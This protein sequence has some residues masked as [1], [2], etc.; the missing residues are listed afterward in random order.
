MKHLKPTT[1]GQRGAVLTDYS[2]LSGKRKVKRLV[3]SFHRSFGRSR[4]S[5]TVRHKGGGNKRLYRIIDF[6]QHK[7]NIPATVEALEYDPNRTGFIALLHYAD[8][9]KRYI[10]AANDMKVGDKVLASEKRIEFSPGNRMPLSH[11][12][13]GSFVHNIEIAPGRGGMLVRSAGASAKVLAHEGKYTNI[14]MPSSEV[15]K[16]LSVG[17]A[18]AGVVS[19]TSHEEE[20]LGKAGRARWRGIR[21][22][23]RG[24]AMNPVDH[25][26]GGGEGRTGIGLRRGPKTP[27]GKLAFGVKTRRKKKYSN[28]FIL[29]RRKSKRR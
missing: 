17:Y 5:I 11:F 4:G 6:K 7:L 29:S 22:T 16:I 21:P 9:D 19:N 23:V 26:H 10:L 20:V 13:I 2:S 18:S 25:P 8:G 1:P 28:V 14:Q 15:R 3:T 12:P 27:W 24:S